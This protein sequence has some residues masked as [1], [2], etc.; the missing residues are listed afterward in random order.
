M[1]PMEIRFV[2]GHELGHFGLGHKAVI[3]DGPSQSEYERLRLRS[4]QRC[5]EIGADRIGLV[6]TGSLFTCAMVMVKLLSGLSE[7]Y[8]KLDVRAFL[9]QLKALEGGGDRRWELTSTHPSLP[10]RLRALI[11]FGQSDVYSRMTGTG[12]GGRALSEVDKEVQGLLDQLGDGWLSKLETDTVGLAAAWLGVSLVLEDGVVTEL[13]REVLHSLI[14]KKL[15]RKALSFGEDLGVDAVHAK[16][17]SATS[18][19]SSSGPR[20]RHRLARIFGA[21]S[22]RLGMDAT[23]TGTWRAVPSWLQEEIVRVYNGPQCE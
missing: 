1:N 21:F 12:G 4:V 15:A 17:A 7:E 22:S 16:L 9:E 14:G 13:E 20:V 23:R 10:L 19:L 18:D 2:L 6:T 8:V 5:S 11:S 3:P